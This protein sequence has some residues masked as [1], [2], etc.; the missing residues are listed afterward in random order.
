MWITWK[1][2]SVIWAVYKVANMAD[3]IEISYEVDNLNDYVADSVKR[4]IT[5]IL[6]IIQLQGG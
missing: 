6:V 1:V 2:K 3:S 5:C 4:M